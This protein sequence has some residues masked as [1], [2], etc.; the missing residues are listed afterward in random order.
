MIAGESRESVD[1]M[2]A[3][4]HAE[5]VALARDLPPDKWRTP[6]LCAGW[7]VGDVL[8]HVADHVHRT[9]AGAFGALAQGLLSPSRAA[10]KVV[11]RHRGDTT[12]RVVTW[13]CEPVRSPSIVQLSELLIHQQDIR[14]AVDAPREIAAPRLSACL[15]FA[16][17]RKGGIAVAGGRHR[18]AGLAFV[19]TDVAWSAG[20]GMSVQGRAEAILMAVNGRAVATRELSG[21]GVATL[22][23]R[24]PSPTRA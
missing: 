20:S 6:S 8:I 5:L 17:S 9:P 23:L 14:R 15:D 1:Q 11:T 16:L 24:C 13:L 4:E 18:A 19:A 3:A 10:E 22:A 21:D 7:T 12:A 2:V